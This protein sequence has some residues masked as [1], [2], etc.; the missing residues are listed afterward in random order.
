VVL[1]ASSYSIPIDLP[2]RP[3]EMAARLLLALTALYVQRPTHTAEEQQQY[4]ELALRLIDKVEAPTHA[5]VADLLQRH[6]DAP[7]EV[8]E[9]LGG[10]QFSRD[11]DPKPEPHSAPDQR[12]AGN[13]Q[14]KG[15]QHLG[16]GQ[17][18]STDAASDAPARGQ[19]AT[20]T[21]EFGEAFFAASAA[22]R[23]RMMSLIADRYHGPVAAPK[24]G[25]RAFASIDAAALH[26]RIGEFTREF[27]R[28]I[29]I[30]RSLCERILHD[31]SGEPMVVA[32]KAA[33]MP[34]AIVQRILLLV[35]P[36]AGHSV[37]RVYDL[38][39]LYHD[40][41]ERAA[42]DLLVQWRM[43]AT[44]SDSLPQLQADA[45]NGR[46]DAPL[47]VSLASLRSRFGAL[48]ER[49]RNQAFN[50]RCD[51]GSVGRRGLQSQ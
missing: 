48:T 41:D 20:R 26:G 49:V 4:S 22:E 8:S 11:G 9:R 38:T 3:S 1:A 45:G 27:E 15:N 34:I 40:L 39:E 17:G 37:E 23:R 12:G 35:N 44:A 24:G 50:V 33:G 19:P 7:A 42:R 46:R 13:P 29:D 14:L 47:S 6:P 36:A 32:A 10:M 21:P 31:P 28:L 5:A 43:R 30:P 25:E 2:E 16:I 51:R 18:A